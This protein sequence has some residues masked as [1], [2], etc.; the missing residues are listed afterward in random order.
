MI[1]KKYLICFILIIA[2]PFKLSGQNHWSQRMYVEANYH[3]GYLMPHSEFISYF[4][5]EHIQ[6]V[7]INVGFIANGDKNWHPSYNFPRIGI[8]Y[9]RSNLSN[10]E[11]YGQL[12]ALFAYAD[13]YYLNWKNWFNFGNRLAFGA[14]YITKK[15]DLHDN[16]T[17]MAIG[18]N[19]NA[20]INYSVETLFRISPYIDYKLGCGITHVSN[21]N[22]H[23]PNKG[24]N[25]FTAFSGLTY[26]FHKPEYITTP[27]QMDDEAD[28][29]HQFSMI[30]SIGRKQIS[31][32]YNESFTV[33]GLSGEYSHLIARNSWG[34]AALSV[35]HDPSIKREIELSDSS[36]VGFSDKVQVTFNL[37]YE[38]KMGRVSYV[39]QPGF[40]LKNSYTA[41]GSIVNKLAIRYELN[42]NLTAGVTIKAHW[43]AIADLFEWGI[44]YRWR[45]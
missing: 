12:N 43:F 24:L 5:K 44:A 25:F 45:K 7:Q 30:S 26:T 14:A 23:Q 17:N 31:R 36:H 34:G 41:N 9:H 28:L 4:V 19:L 15:F 18:S 29:K 27:S 38:L 10:R 37:V 1:L 33:I 42:K 11:V 40:Y 20:Y 3:Y 21:G 13:R 6:G 22:I 32:K 35:Y 8:G 16:G 2:F 39:F